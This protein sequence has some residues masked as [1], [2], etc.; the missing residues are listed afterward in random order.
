[1]KKEQRI[2]ILLLLL[3]VAV[4]MLFAAN[5]LMPQQSKGKSNQIKLP[6]NTPAPTK[7]AYSEVTIK[8]MILSVDTKK[9]EITYQ[10][11]GTG[12]EITVAYST[13]TDITDKYG[14]VL[15]AGSLNF[16]DLVDVTCN[17]KTEEL[18]SL[19]RSSDHWEMRSVDNFS[20]ALPEYR[21][22]IG[23][24][25]YKLTDNTIVIQD[26]NIVPIESLHERDVLRVYGT[27]MEILLLE[28]RKGHGY[29][30]LENAEGLYGGTITI[31]T[32]E[33][34]IEAGSVYTVREG[35]YQVLLQ[36]AEDISAADVTVEKNTTVVIDAAEYGGAIPD[37]G[38]VW[39]TI[40]PFGAKLYIDG[41]DTYYYETEV[42]LEYG[43]YEI[44][45]SLGG[46]ISCTG[47]IKVDRPYQNYKFELVENLTEE[48]TDNT[49]TEQDNSDGEDSS[50]SESDTDRTGSTDDDT[51][52][53]E[54]ATV[55]SVA[56]VLDYVLDDAHKTYINKPEGAKVYIDDY[57]IGTVP[58]AFEKIL[59][60]FVLVLK[61]GEREKSYTITPDDNNE[62][63]P[64]SFPDI[65]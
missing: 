57:Y 48:D 35:A 4:I 30:R 19:T 49:D 21:F 14:K 54:D 6:T 56:G 36:N 45:V 55:V 40:E 16:G 1:M 13:K 3:T 12:E 11:F 62:D 47:T 8:G 29:L 51:Q 27:D 26:G 31:G 41:E 53:S 46:Y 59:D 23:G 33:Y 15:V 25:N 18:L 9:K 34:P 32:F 42:E 37:K 65:N 64:Y 5:A 38:L 50:G 60:P 17:S 39:F 52:V 10:S 63:A 2:V 58:L 28:V 24:T 20:L 43:T 22:T 7:E 44:E 61:D